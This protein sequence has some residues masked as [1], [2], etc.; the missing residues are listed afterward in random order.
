MPGEHEA[1]RE[2]KK[3]NGEIRNIETALS[4]GG[5][6]LS[7]SPAIKPAACTLTSIEKNVTHCQFVRH[8]G[9]HNNEILSMHIRRP[10]RFA[11]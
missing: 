11:Q 1:G 5:L 7:H 4:R 8:A 10:S 6:F 2:V 3:S 9:N